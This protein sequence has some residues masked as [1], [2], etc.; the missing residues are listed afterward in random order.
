MSLPTPGF[1]ISAFFQVCR[2]FPGTM[3]CVILG[4]I[5]CF[6][7]IENGGP[8]DSEEFFARNW[9]TCQLGLPFL[10]AL[11]AY[12]ESK[13]W[14]EKRGWLLQIIGF[15]ALVGC[16]F[17]LDTKAADF[18]WRI[19]PQYLALMI[20]MHLAV[21]VAPFLNARSVRE[22]WEYNRELF[23]N[24]VVG[25]AFTLILYAGLALALLAVDN[26]FNFNVQEKAYAKLFVLLAGIFNTAYFLFHFPPAFAKATAGETATAPSFAEATAGKTAGETATISE[27]AYN[28]VFRNLCKYILIPIVILYFL[29]LYAYGAKIGL[30]WLLPRGWVSSL[31]VGFSVAGIFTY[32]LNFY[33]AEEDNSVIVK[34]FKRWFWWVVLPLTVLLFVAIGKRLSDYGVTEERYLVAELGVWLAASCLYFLFS[35]ND[36][37]KFIPI[38]LAL[39]ALF[40]AFGPLSA[41]TVSERSQKGILTEILERNGRFENGKLKP[42]T[43]ALTEPEQNQ[44]SSAILYLE[45]RNVLSEL[46]PTP[47]D[48]TLLEYDG[49]LN[50]LKIGEGA[51]PKMNSL[52][53]SAINSSEPLDVRGFDMAYKADLLPKNDRESEEPGYFFSLSDDGKM[54][55][56]RETKAGKS[57][58]I[59]TFSLN[60]SIQKWLEKMDKTES[61]T[62]LRLPVNERTIPFYGRRGTL[63]F[64]VQEVHIEV[65]G[66]EKR[67]DYC[68]GWILLKEK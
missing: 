43:A 8:S 21:A 5:A 9:I 56:W 24:L 13:G 53:I 37:I 50:W 61:Y 44:V 45:K 33:L 23:A 68:N 16:W 1:L 3:L 2:R 36:N 46:L 7:L 27:P 63:R 26:L 32:L 57:A 34:G 11:V 66:Q 4:T 12:S 59:E 31:V 58:L 14:S 18:E 51:N 29:I 39:F 30:E 6:A 28:W 60:P 48:S 62:H 25:A 67:L 42:G 64:I 17:W 20:V 40:W 47:I 55:E 65:D 41:F 10:T 38:S 52:N 22:F 54:L 19:L 15:L 49:L 35:K